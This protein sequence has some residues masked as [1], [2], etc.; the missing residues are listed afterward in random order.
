VGDVWAVHTFFLSS[1]TVLEGTDPILSGILGNVFNGVT[2]SGGAAGLFKA[3]FAKLR[4]VSAAY[5]L[6]ERIARWVGASRGTITVSGENLAFLWRAQKEAYGV[7]WVD[8][9]ISANSSGSF[10]MLGY[11]GYIQESLPQSARIR[12]TIRLTF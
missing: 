8:P 3:G 10:G 5:E 9:E 4:S 1:K 7:G 6:P 2:N 12:T 11:L